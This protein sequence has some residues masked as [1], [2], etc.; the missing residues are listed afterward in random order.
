MKPED[1]AALLPE[2]FRRTAESSSPLAVLLE[3]MSQL[4]APCER[5]LEEL[6]AAF[7]P[8][9]TRESFLP[10]LA[11]WVGH[12]APD[13][14]GAA[15]TRLLIAEAAEISRERGTARALLRRLATATG[16]R[17]FRLVESNEQAFHL[18]VLV[19]KAAADQ[20]TRVQAVVQDEK[21]AHLTHQLVV[22][23]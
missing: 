4:H 10:L 15:A 16:V 17:G 14:V 6:D 21:P 11:S 20:L 12:P 2:V 3:L 1:I 5:E 9:R 7:D 19:P 13:T 8:L 18:I 22:S 23:R